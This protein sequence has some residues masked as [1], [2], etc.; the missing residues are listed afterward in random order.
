MLEETGFVCF[1]QC[2]ICVRAEESGFNQLKWVGVQK[3][4]GFCEKSGS[5]HTLQTEGPHLDKVHF[6]WPFVFTSQCQGL[7]GAIDCLRWPSNWEQKVHHSAVLKMFKSLPFPEK[8]VCSL[9]PSCSFL[10]YMHW[11][12]L[13]TLTPVPQAD[14]EMSSYKT[15]A[16]VSQIC[17]WLWE[18]HSWNNVWL[19]I[20][21]FCYGTW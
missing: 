20:D 7:D 4:E 11:Q 5:R 12:R 13:M 14:I 19:G 17:W 10:E 18:S 1:F 6:P 3:A 15:L 2:S 9:M 16:V 8:W 21:L